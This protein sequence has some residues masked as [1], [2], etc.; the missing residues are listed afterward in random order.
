MESRRKL[1]LMAPLSTILNDIV[2]IIAFRDRGGREKGC[3]GLP[4]AES[5]IG[6]REILFWR[7]GAGFA[8][9]RS[10]GAG[11]EDSIDFEG[12]TVSFMR[13]RFC[14]TDFALDPGA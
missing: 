7:A 5:R 2:G 9:E 11:T 4:N 14:M 8:P 13:V 1:S 6:G 12:D 3:T 10:D